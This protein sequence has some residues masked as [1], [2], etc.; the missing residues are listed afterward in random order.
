MVVAPKQNTGKPRRTVDLQSVNEATYRETHHTETPHRLVS[1]VPA[2]QKKTVLDCWNGY[3]SL[4]LAESARDATCFITEWGRYRY[5]RAPQGFHASGDGYTKRMDDIVAG[6]T[7]MKKCIDDTLL[8][9][10]D[11]EEIFWHTVG[12]VDLCSRNGI[13]FNPDKF[14]FGSDEVEFAGFEITLDG[15]RPTKKMLSAIAN[16]PT[17]TDLT[18]VRSW[19][20][21]VEQ[22]SYAFAKSEVMSPF[23]DLL[24]KKK[25]FYW[26]QQ[27]TNIF[28]K[29]R[30]QVV[31]K[32]KEGVKLFEIG[33]ETFLGTDWSK[34]G[35]GYVMKQKHC[36]CP[37]DKAPFCG[38]D[39]W[40]LIAIGSRFLKDAETRYA[41]IE[42]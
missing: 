14:V 20:G 28:L 39:H 12:Y 15:Y 42:G 32:V 11:M 19:F 24:Q 23:R 3:H 31:D 35:V 9:S 18:G 34:T 5:L 13:V 36:K 8:Y 6:T 27:L 37:M 21:L 1:N 17:P 26:D 16:F 33:R 10:D 7:N 4:E 29:A 38:E 30:C 41:P 40:K 22:V 2:G 25:K